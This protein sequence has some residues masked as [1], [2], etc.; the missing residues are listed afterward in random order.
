MTPAERMNDAGEAALKVTIYSD[1]I[2]PWCYIGKRRFETALEDPAMPQDPAISWRPFELNPDMPDDGM[3]RTAYRARKFGAEKAKQLDLQMAQNG[4]EAGINFAF[5]KMK[6][7]PNTRLA[8]RL[9]WQA[10]QEGAEVQNALVNRLFAAYFEEGAD[11]GRKDVLLEIA[12]EAGLG[13]VPA[14]VALYD[15]ESLEAVLNLEDAGIRMGIRGVPFFILV[16]KYA[17]SGAQ[18]PELWRDALP[19]IVAESRT[20]TP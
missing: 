20:G 15:E 16:D 4:R 5:D 1:V 3:E 18:P 13:N 9:I 11:I 12:K 14:K 6:R 10:G 2:C 7:T 19:R 8:H 17:V